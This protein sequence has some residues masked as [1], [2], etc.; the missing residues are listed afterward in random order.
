[1]ENARIARQ[2]IDLQTISE[3]S[4]VSSKEGKNRDNRG[5]ERG[6]S[7]RES[8]VQPYVVNDKRKKSRDNTAGVNATVEY[9]DHPL[10]RYSS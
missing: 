9:V 10:D 2:R 4:L 7:L 5:E 8:R 1:M 3:P 6:S